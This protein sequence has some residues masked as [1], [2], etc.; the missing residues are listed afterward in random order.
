MN[1]EKFTQKSLQALNL[2]T[3][4]AKE[5]GNQQINSLHLLYALTTDE[6]GV[7]V[8]L[9]EKMNVS[10]K[11]VADELMSAINKLPKVQGKGGEYASDDLAIVIDAAEK[12]AGE[13]K[14]EFISVE[15]LVYGIIEKPSKEIKPILTA[16]NINKDA[17]FRRTYANSW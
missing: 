15:Y 1:S 10:A 17:F 3:S 12:K 2:A 11:K 14:D 8:R 5:N 6:E 9:F 7:V 13:M 4:T 16:N